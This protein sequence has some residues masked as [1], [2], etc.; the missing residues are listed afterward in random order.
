[1]SHVE[2]ISIKIHF[3]IPVSLILFQAGLMVSGAYVG[4][5]RYGLPDAVLFLACYVVLGT[6]YMAIGLSWARRRVREMIETA[7]GDE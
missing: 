4:Y 5:F 6:T 7:W 2:K 1:M 3:P